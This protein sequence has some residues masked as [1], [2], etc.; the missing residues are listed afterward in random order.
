MKSN[1]I[2]TEI[3]QN[4]KDLDSVIIEYQKACEDH[5]EIK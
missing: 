4:P 2:V 1:K 3:I 5:L